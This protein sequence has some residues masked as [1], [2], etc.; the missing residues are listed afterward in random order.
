MAV[1]AVEAPAEVFK[2][3]LLMANVVESSF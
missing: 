2:I 1:S 3:V